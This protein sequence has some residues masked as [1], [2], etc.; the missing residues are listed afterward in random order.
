MKLEMGKTTK[1]VFG[2]RSVLGGALA[3]AQS[4]LADGPEAGVPADSRVR[5]RCGKK[6]E[7][8][9]PLGTSSKQV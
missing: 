6:P 8:L 7:A 3:A 9:L 1:R 2:G 4:P 5:A